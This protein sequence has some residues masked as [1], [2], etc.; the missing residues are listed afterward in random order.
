MLKNPS[1]IEEFLENNNNTSVYAIIWTTTPWTLPANQ[2]I[3]YN[4]DLDYSLVKFQNND[5]SLYI[6]ASKTISQLSNLINESIEE[7]LTFSGTLLKGCTYLHPIDNTEI[8]PFLSGKH[9][10]ADKGTGLV[11]TAPAH[12]PDDFL[13]SLEHNIKMVSYFQLSFLY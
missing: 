5:K 10:Q 4:Q 11:H 1:I 9:V 12:G 8:N 3:C 7:V 2:A 6:V 13:V